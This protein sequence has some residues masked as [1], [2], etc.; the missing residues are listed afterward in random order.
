MRVFRL[1]DVPMCVHVWL[2]LENPG[3]SSSTWLLTENLL[4]SKELASGL[5]H[6]GLLFIL[7]GYL[8]FFHSLSSESPDPGVCEKTTVLSPVQA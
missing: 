8:Q 2:F 3:C 4:S 5:G 7:H 1:A 6:E